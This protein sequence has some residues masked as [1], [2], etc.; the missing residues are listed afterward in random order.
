MVYA[1]QT[2]PHCV[3]QMGKAQ[4]KPLAE[5]HG[6]CE[7]ALSPLVP[8]NIKCDFPTSSSDQILFSHYSVY[9]WN[10]MGAW[11][12]LI[13]LRIETNGSEIEGDFL[14]GFA[15]RSRD[16]LQAVVVAQL[17]SGRRNVIYCYPSGLDRPVV[18]R[19]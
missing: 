1:S 14:T 3:N 13:W 12:G 5:R 11:T 9:S 7:S 19:E 10:S 8:L 2:R 6:M 15:A 17:A 4:S 18:R 16:T